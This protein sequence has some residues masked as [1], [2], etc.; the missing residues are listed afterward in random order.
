MAKLLLA[1]G[2]DVNLENSDGQKALHLASWAGHEEVVKLLLA[3]GADVNQAA[4]GGSKPLHWACSGR[5]SKYMVKLLLDAG[6]DTEAQDGHGK[7]ALALAKLIYEDVSMQ[8]RESEEKAAL[9]GL[10]SGN[11]LRDMRLEIAKRDNLV[12]AITVLGKL[13]S[14]GEDEILVETMGLRSV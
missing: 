12:G 5:R 9:V 6:A 3:A 1:G 8:S 14:R 7:T 13:A 4:R 2:A 10:F 11:D